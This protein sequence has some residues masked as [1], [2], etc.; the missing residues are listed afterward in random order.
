V[1]PSSLLDATMNVLAR[2]GRG[3]V[4]RAAQE[5]VA[6]HNGSA[7]LP[8]GMSRL[9]GARIL[10]VEDNEINQL[11]AREMLTDAGLVVE[12]AENGQVAVE[13][14][15]AGRYDLVF[16]DMQMPVMDGVQATQHIRQLHAAAQ[17]PVLA[18]TANAMEQDRQVCLAAG[19]NDT[20]TK[21][22]D[23]AALWAA[24]LRWIPARADDCAPLVQAGCAPASSQ[25]DGIDGLEPAFGLKQAS[26]K[27]VLYRQ[28]LGVFVRQQ[29]DCPARIHQALADGDLAEAER[30]AHTLK[31]VAAGLG[32]QLVSDRAGAVEAALRTYLP[33]AVVQQR[34]AELR[35]PLDELVA[36][37][38][39]RLQE[40]VAA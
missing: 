10:L 15:K 3:Q 20:V 36:A 8:E 7:Q 32:A 40:P 19:M 27:P 39:A 30:L 24:L 4:R 5:P 37:L 18:M 31:G 13:M 34:L 28:L 26:N 23:P 9:R 17:L 33:P 16:M 11:V 14:V 12:I 21:P 35:P 25:W 2:E 22:I 29:A 6:S 38:A 1:R